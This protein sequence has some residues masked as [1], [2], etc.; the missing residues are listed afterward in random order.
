MFMMSP[1]RCWSSNNTAEGGVRCNE[2]LGDRAPRV[3][4]ALPRWEPTERATIATALPPNNFW[5]F[6]VACA[7]AVGTCNGVGRP[8]WQERDELRN[9]L[10]GNLEVI[11]TKIFVEVLQLR[12]VFIEVYEGEI[13][14]DT[15]PP[16]PASRDGKHVTTQKLGHLVVRE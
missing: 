13:R 11:E 12:G 9:F 1:T 7:S 4:L 15:Y 16:G 8:C 5:L 2:G 10:R 6:I 14:R 3:V